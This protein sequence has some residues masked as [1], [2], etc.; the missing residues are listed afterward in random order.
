MTQAQKQV[1]ELVADNAR[2]RQRLEGELQRAAEFE[3]R[4]AD[5]RVV[6]ETA[7]RPR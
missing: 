4:L 6:G 7:R 2:L 1:E 5:A 3:R